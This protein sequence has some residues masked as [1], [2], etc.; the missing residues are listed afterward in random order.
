MLRA[1]AQYAEAGAVG[2]LAR[3]EQIGNS[4]PVRSLARK[5]AGTHLHDQVLK[6]F[7]PDN[8]AR[9]DHR[10]RRRPLWRRPPA[11]ARSFLPKH[12]RSTP[13]CNS[14]AS[15]AGQVAGT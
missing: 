10:H 5:R 6:A 15:A 14:R 2:A 11:P 9:E 8:T 1:T 3:S 4:D 7:G 12:G 13:A